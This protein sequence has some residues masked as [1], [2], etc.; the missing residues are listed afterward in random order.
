MRESLKTKAFG[1]FILKGE[2]KLRIETRVSD[3]GSDIKKDY[4]QH[5]ENPLL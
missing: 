3:G 5:A 1:G 2:W 4:N